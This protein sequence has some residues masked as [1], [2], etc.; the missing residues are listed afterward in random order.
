MHSV[1]RS[2]TGHIT[3]STPASMPK[4]GRRSNGPLCLLLCIVGLFGFIVMVS[5][6][7]PSDTR[8][9]F[10]EKVSTLCGKYP[11]FGCPAPANLAKFAFD[12]FSSPVA[13][14]VRCLVPTVPQI[15][16]HGSCNTCA[17]HRLPL[18][19]SRVGR[20]RGQL[21]ARIKEAGE[22]DARLQPLLKRIDR[23][24]GD[25]GA[26]EQ[27]ADQMIHKRQ[28]QAN[29]AHEAIQ[30]GARAIANSDLPASAPR[31]AA[32]MAPAAQLPNNPPAKAAARAAP[33]APV[34]PA[35]PRGGA[36]DD[37]MPK[38]WRADGRCGPNYPAPGEFG[39]PVTAGRPPWQAG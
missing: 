17:L 13:A 37:G 20:F 23:F 39:A 4:C 10:E 31:A 18:P 22:P 25:V 3:R 27:R 8:F 2:D 38:S 28:Q 30:D 16:P 24:A 9:Q 15:S 34:A 21:E 32:P 26:V 19:S 5:R 7:A 33:V 14:C 36:V 29:I 11:M 12:C 1:D 6:P 35:V